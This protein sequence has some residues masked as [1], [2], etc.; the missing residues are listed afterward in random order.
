M[1]II[2]VGGGGAAVGAHTYY[3]LGQKCPMVFWNE[4]ANERKG[5]LY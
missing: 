5:A 3:V 1:L 4:I 2:S